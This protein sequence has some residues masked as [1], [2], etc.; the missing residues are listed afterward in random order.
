MILRRIGVA[1]RARDWTAVAIEFAIVVL[2]IFVALQAENWNQERR[3]RQLER[4]Y[5]ARLIDETRANLVLLNELQQILDD[6]IDFIVA[7]PALSLDEAFRQGPQEFMSRLDYSTYLA[8]PGLRSETYQELESSGRL[9]LLR[10][11][12]LRSA[13]ANNLND[14][15]SAR[16]F[17]LEPIG[18]YRLILSET[19]PGRLFNDYRVGNG[20]TDT[21]AAIA[22]VEAFRKDPRFGAAA[23]A[24]IWYSADLMFHIREF[25]RRTEDILARLESSG[26]TGTVRDVPRPLIERPRSREATGVSEGP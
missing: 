3:D 11:T 4:V 2:G 6:K 1:I 21:A 12:E 14:Y 24:E 25:K 16:P 23:N 18:D 10:D 17:F 8:L 26:I 15:E 22:A 9:S 13:I 5:I 20:V 19:L 7:L